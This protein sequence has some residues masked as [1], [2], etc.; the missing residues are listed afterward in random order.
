MISVG[1]KY[2]PRFRHLNQFL[3]YVSF[4]YAKIT[5]I[6]FTTENVKSAAT[7]FKHPLLLE[8]NISTLTILV[9]AVV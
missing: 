9:Y 5:K 7:T 3:R 1:P 4:N 2:C 8:N 6:Y